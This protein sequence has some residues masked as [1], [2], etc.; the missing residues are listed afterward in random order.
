MNYSIILIGA[1]NRCLYYFALMMAVFIFA[2]AAK[3]KL[4]CDPINM[5]RQT[6]RCLNTLDL[7]RKSTWQ[8]AH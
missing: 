1:E 5:A 4:F 2:P 3:L 6:E 8:R 7:S